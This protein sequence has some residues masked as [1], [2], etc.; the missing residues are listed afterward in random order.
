[1]TLVWSVED[2]GTEAQRLN[3]FDDEDRVFD[4][5]NFAGTTVRDDAE[6]TRFH[7][8]LNEQTSCLCTQDRSTTVEVEVEPGD[9]LT[10]WSLYAV[11]ADVEAL[12][13]EV[14]EFGDITEV[15]IS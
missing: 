10:Y 3:W 1:M 9:K 2:T 8:V 14:P 15:P 7:P 11:P 5:P 13:V 6:R 4:R 12:N